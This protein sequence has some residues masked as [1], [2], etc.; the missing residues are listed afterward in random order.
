MVIVW[1]Y[2]IFNY[3]R[4]RDSIFRGASSI[5]LSVQEIKA[6]LVYCKKYGGINSTS[7]VEVVEV[8][9]VAVADVAEVG[10]A[11]VRF[12]PRCCTRKCLAFSPSKAFCPFLIIFAKLLPISRTRYMPREMRWTWGDDNLTTKVS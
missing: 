5:D 7:I 1:T 3:Y 4:G 11:A 12:H 10:V 2:A 8:V 6:F 9:E